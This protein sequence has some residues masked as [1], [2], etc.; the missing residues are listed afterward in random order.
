MPDKK[1]CQEF[2]WYICLWIT[3]LPSVISICVHHCSTD[4]AVCSSSIASYMTTKWAVTCH[5][6]CIKASSH[7]YRYLE[8]PLVTHKNTEETDAACGFVKY[9]EWLGAANEQLKWYLYNQILLNKCY[10]YQHVS[11]ES[12][13]R[14]HK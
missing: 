6:C 3:Y 8:A 14:L 11:A 1:S 7:V 10:I 13:S 5:D 12:I 2:Y 4:P 9:F